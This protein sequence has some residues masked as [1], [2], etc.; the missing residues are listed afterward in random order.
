LIQIFQSNAIKILLINIT[1]NRLTI[2]QIANI[3]PNHFIIFTQKINSIIEIISHVTFESHIADHDFTNQ[4]LID[5]SKLFH[6]FN[7]SFILSNISILA[8][9]AIPIDKISP[10]I[11][12]KVK[13]IHNN[14]I[15][16][17]TK[18]IYIS[19]A[20]EAIKPDNL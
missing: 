6:I 4:I 8:S 9:I 5:F 14:F 15:I 17:K 7:S 16:D 10:A 11:D 2:I 13:T 1:E 18:T 19:K 3:K 12:A 20:I